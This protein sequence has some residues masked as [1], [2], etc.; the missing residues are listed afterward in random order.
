MCFCGDKK[1]RYSDICTHI[2]LVLEQEIAAGADKQPIVALCI[3]MQSYFVL[4]F[5]WHRCKKFVKTPIFYI[6]TRYEKTSMPCLM[7]INHDLRKHTACKSNNCT[8]FSFLPRSPAKCGY[9]IARVCTS[10]MHVCHKM[11]NE[12]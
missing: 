1:P 8:G 4:F 3:V 9:V 10:S 11:C 12:H 5:P 6:L 7:W 2:V